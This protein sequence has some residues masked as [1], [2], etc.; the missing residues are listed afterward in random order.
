[1]RTS[2]RVTC[3]RGTHCADHRNAERPQ[4]EAH[5]HALATVARGDSRFVKTVKAHRHPW[6]AFV[7]TVDSVLSARHDTDGTINPLGRNVRM[8]NSTTCHLTH[9]L[10]PP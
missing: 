2:H 4:S 1:L 5:H 3:G 6:A 7:R 8:P 9:L 10:S